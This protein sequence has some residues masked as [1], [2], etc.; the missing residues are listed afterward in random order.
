MAIKIAPGTLAKIGQPNHGSLTQREVEECF[1]NHDGRLCWDSR[2]E[3]LD[4]EGNPI[5]WFVAETNHR[6]LL[7]IMFVRDGEDV[8]LKSAYPATQQVHD[9]FERR[10]K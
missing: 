4:R 8:E 1:E 7:K 3:H 6:R 9:I 5:P 10:S 2:P